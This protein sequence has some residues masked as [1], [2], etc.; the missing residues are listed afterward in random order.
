MFISMSLFYFNKSFL[1]VWVFISTLQIT[2]L[3]A[4][5]YQIPKRK[6]IAQKLEKMLFHG[7][8]QLNNSWNNVDTKQINIKKL[9][10]PYRPKIMVFSRDIKIIRPSKNFENKQ[11]GL[12]QIM[13]KHGE[14]YKWNDFLIWNTPNI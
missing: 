5:V 10:L 6:N 1:P 12:Y 14:S 2:S 8:E 4:N 9:F 3:F 7:T 11:L 13:A